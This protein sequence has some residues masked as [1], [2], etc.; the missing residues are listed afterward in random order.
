[1]SHGEAHRG[2]GLRWYRGIALAGRRHGREISARGHGF[3]RPSY[4]ST[5]RRA[6]RGVAVGGHG[7]YGEPRGGGGAGVGVV[8]CRTAR[9]RRGQWWGVGVEK[10]VVVVGL[11]WVLYLKP[12][13]TGAH[14]GRYTSFGEA[15]LVVGWREGAGGVRRRVHAMERSRGCV[16]VVVWWRRGGET[17]GK[18]TI[19]SWP[20]V[21][22]G[23]MQ[24][25][26][27]GRRLLSP[28]N[29]RAQPCGLTRSPGRRQNDG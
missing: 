27:G 28:I 29:A 20:T 1:M 10:W 7:G 17:L 19:K 24:T 18:L 6:W 15:E 11:A 21:I 4:L 9:G 14:C 13:R 16:V 3:G 5:N 22:T 26:L 2:R 8:C 23:I 12:R 25:R